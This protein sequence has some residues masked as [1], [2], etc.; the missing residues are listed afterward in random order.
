MIMN[1][2]RSTGA[3]MTMGK[4]K[5]FRDMSLEEQIIYYQNKASRLKKKQ[6]EQ[7][8]DHHRTIGRIFEDVFGCV[9]GTDEEIKAT[10]NKMS[11]MISAYQHRATVKSTS[12]EKAPASA[13]EPASAAGL[14][15]P[16]AAQ[17]PAGPN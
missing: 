5:K 9:T 10:L 14:T 7:L 1:D 17:S 6:A 4:D 11:H 13:E 3:I 2:T 16:L 12:T 8:A 15:P